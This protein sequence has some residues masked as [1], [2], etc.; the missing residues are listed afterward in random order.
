MGYYFVNT[1]L[2]MTSLSDK[3]AA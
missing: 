1:L 3:M 2:V